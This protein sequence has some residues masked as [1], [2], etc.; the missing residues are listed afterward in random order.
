[1]CTLSRQNKPRMQHKHPCQETNS[2]PG[3]VMHAT[4]THSRLNPLL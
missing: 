1:V 3:R 2:N 4:G